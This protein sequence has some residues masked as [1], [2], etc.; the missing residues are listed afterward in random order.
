MDSMQSF[1]FSLRLLL[2]YMQRIFT[3]SVGDIPDG[4]PQRSKELLHSS[5]LCLVCFTLCA[6]TTECAK[7]PLEELL[8]YVNLGI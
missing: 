4:K 7:Q 8:I 6:Y 3:N 2:S 1:N 5:C